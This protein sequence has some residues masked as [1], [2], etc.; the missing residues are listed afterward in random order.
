MAKKPTKPTS[1]SETVKHLGG[2]GLKKPKSL[3]P[4]QV[5]ELAGSVEAHIQPRGKNKK[6]PK[7]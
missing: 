7:K 6:P 3:E 4:K 1:T 2:K 5:Q